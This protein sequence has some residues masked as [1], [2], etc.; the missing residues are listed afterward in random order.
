MAERRKTAAPDIE[1][2]QRRAVV[3][4]AQAMSRDG[5]SP[6]R[7][8]NVSA[9]HSDGALITPTGLPYETLTPE[10]IV[11]VRSD[12]ATEPGSLLPSSEW[13]LHLAIYAT[14]PSAQA[15]VHCHSPNAT[16]LACAGRAIPAFHYMVAVAGGVDV[17]LAPYA[18]FGTPELAELVA[19]T[20]RGRRA[21][22]LAHHGQI[23]FGATL[24]SALDLAREVEVLAMQYIKT[25]QIGGGPIL[26]EAAM[27]EV[28][29]RFRDYGQQKKAAP[30]KRRP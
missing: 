2:A 7:S 15:V 16:A 22:L 8:G 3:E 1:L 28:L 10:Q 4:T 24:N 9:R 18:T 25:L 11:F 20:L 6:G 19:A 26:D 5:L 12:G 29:S 17:P 27:A 21:C 30:R 14:H 23:A 13:R